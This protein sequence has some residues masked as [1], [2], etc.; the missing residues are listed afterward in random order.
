MSFEQTRDHRLEAALQS[1]RFTGE[2]GALT[3][4]GSGRGTRL[5][6]RWRIRAGLPSRTVSPPSMRGVRHRRPKDVPACARLLRVVHDQDGY[7][8]DW[9]DAPRAWLAGEHLLE[10]WVA[11]RQGEILGHVA[12]APVGVEGVSRFRWQETTGRT[13]AEL[14][15]VTMLFVRPRV[16]GQGIGTALLAVAA[17]GIGARGLLP[18]IE[19]VGE[20]AMK[21]LDSRGWRRVATDPLPGGR[22]RSRVHLYVGRRAPADGSSR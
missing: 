6:H 18:V 21:L 19:V 20:P 14:V 7:P 5:G 3:S 11:E 13:H 4:V 8:L 12:I 2:V 15:A 17:D 22:D 10:A 16:R 9:P 1:G